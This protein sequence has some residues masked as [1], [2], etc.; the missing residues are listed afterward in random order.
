MGATAGETGLRE[1]GEGVWNTF[2]TLRFASE[3]F[4]GHLGMQSGQS[5]MLGK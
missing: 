4:S 3:L 1:L 5:L 2:D